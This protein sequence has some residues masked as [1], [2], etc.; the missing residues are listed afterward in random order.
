MKRRLFAILLAAVACFG[1][2]FA[3]SACGGSSLQMNKNI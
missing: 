3:L 1:V 2:L